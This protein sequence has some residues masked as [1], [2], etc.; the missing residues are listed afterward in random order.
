MKCSILYKPKL[1]CIFFLSPVTKFEARLSDTCVNA[2]LYNALG[3]PLMH[4][5]ALPSPEIVP[6]AISP[7]Q[8]AAAPP[9]TVEV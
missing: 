3:L 7:A 9:N 4:R 8:A 2:A 6:G 5:A 1:F